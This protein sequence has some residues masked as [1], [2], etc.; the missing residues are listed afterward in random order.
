MGLVDCEP[1]AMRIG[2][3]VRL[4]CDVGW[5]DAED[6]EVVAYRFALEDAAR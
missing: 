4:V 1:D 6:R 3:R 5:T 2:A